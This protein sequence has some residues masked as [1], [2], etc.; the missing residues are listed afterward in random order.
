[1]KFL[2]NA[3]LTGNEIQKAGRIEFSTALGEQ[4]PEPGAL[5][6]NAEDVT[7]S[8]GT[9]N[10]SA[11]E[12]GQEILY[13]VI[14]QSGATIENGTVVMSDGVVGLS[15]K[16]KVVPADF[17]GSY[18]CN[19]VIGLVTHD[20]AN[21]ANT[22]GDSVGEVWAD[23]DELWGHPSQ[24][25]KLTKNKP[26]A[27]AIKVAVATVVNAD[28]AVGTLLVRMTLGSKLGESDS[29]VKIINVAD[30]DIL[31]YNST[32]SLWENEQIPLATT[33][34]D[35]FMSSADKSK[36]DDIENN[37]TADMTPNEILTAVKTVDGSGSGLDADTLDGKH[38]SEFLGATEQAN[39]SD[40]LNNQHGSYYLDRTNHTGTQTASTISDFNTE[41]ENNSAVLA[42]TASRHDHSNKA[43]LDAIEEAF[44]TILK[45]KLDGI[46]SEAEVNTVDSV[47]GKTGAVDLSADY[48]PKNSN[49]QTH[50][51]ST[52]NPHSVDKNDVGLGNVDNVQQIPMSQKGANSGVAELD[53]NGKI[54]TTH[55]PSFVDDVIEAS[56]LANLPTTGENGKIYVTTDNNKVYRWSGTAYIE[57]SAS[58]TLGETSSTAYRGDRGKIAYDH[59][60]TAH[61]PSNAEVNNISD[62]DAIDL[63]DGGDSSLHYHSADR[64]RSNHT[65]T[66]TASTISDFDT[67]V[68]NN[69]D[70]AANTSAR[71]THTNKTV[72]D[73]FSESEGEP[74]YDGEP[75]GGGLTGIIDSRGTTTISADSDTVA[76]AIPDFD[77]DRDSLMVHQ[78][79]VFL[80][81]YTIDNVNNTIIKNSG[82]WDAG[83][84]FDFISFQVAALDP[85]VGL[86]QG[87][88]AIK[89]QEF[90]AT[91]GQTVFTISNGSYTQN[92]NRLSVYVW[93]SKQFNNAFTET[94][95]TS[96]TMASPL[97]AG[98]KV[99]AEWI[100]AVNI[101]GLYEGHA[102]THAIGGSDQ[103]TPAMIGAEFSVIGGGKPTNGATMWYEEVV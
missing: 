101:E 100:E 17:S 30:K 98:D 82:T 80:T 66:Q 3:D 56:S 26:A 49:I 37:A 4:S 44:T 60:Q 51:A 88:F 24:P 55:L 93:G 77:S 87:I 41:V 68:S 73:K 63:T 45:D 25:G 35:G 95:T 27:P 5:Y 28:S 58:I 53:S 57:I 23:G 40:K 84:V 22:T 43:T 69:T 42:N 65:G 38:A 71:H 92:S 34:I 12:I 36:L 8:L 33:S 6:W 85:E 74:L 47:D 19:K 89:R 99:I 54:L 39:D 83:T 13:P 78:N 52:S 2:S 16:I 86:L 21:G 102:S 10:G 46:E 79:S 90:T 96:F 9:L 32:T 11:I 18:E 61:A 72:L 67:E 103:I 20:I 70:V 15:G 81:D 64:N 97:S 7:L 29:N 62:T 76:I 59:S 91:E 1:M 48:E 94:S 31:Q 75:L 50:I 14:N